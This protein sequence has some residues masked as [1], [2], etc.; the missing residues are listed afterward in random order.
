MRPILATLLL[1]VLAT[2]AD[3][4]VRPDSTRP[5]VEFND[6]GITFNAR[7]GVSFLNLRFRLQEW[8]VVTGADNSTTVSRTQIAARRARLRL[9]SVLWDPRL[10]MVMQLSFAR[11]DQDPELPAIVSVLRDAVVRWRATNHLTLAMG[12]TKLPVNRQKMNSSGELQFADRSIVS[13]ALGVDRDV[14]IFAHYEQHDQLM[15]V[16][17][18]VAITEGE[19]RNPSTGD[20][21][22]AYTARV[23][24][25]PLGNFLS[26]GDFVEGDV[27]HEPRAKLSLGAAISHNDGAVRTAGQ[28][29]KALFQPRS[30]T[31]MIV[32]GLFKRK[33]FSFATEY[34]RRSAN[35]PITTNGTETRYVLT[36]EG[37]SA[38]AG[39]VL[40]SRFEPVIRFS[41]VSPHAD[42]AR[43][44]DVEHQREFSAGLN[45][46]LKGHRVKMQWELLRDEYRKL[47]TG[48]RRA[49]W[50][51]RTSLEVGI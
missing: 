3:A 27:A 1:S 51:V 7:D 36:G 18:R 19:G 28:L 24:V 32:D 43:L 46:Y 41:Q 45:R 15:P 50:T 30:M 26:N 4:Q 40:P 25:L 47:L 5:V 17:V 10:S 37:I 14:G 42:L 29:G 22:L 23:E 38:Q 2:A 12:Q 21:G 16:N 34:S 11:G 35:D 8:A 6:R 13:S 49:N 9:E 39:F 31:S 33:G 20:A 44:P 48:T